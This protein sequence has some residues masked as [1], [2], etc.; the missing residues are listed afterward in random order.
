MVAMT[1]RSILPAQPSAETPV[2]A[3]GRTRVIAPITARQAR[4]GRQP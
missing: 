1:G 2:G 4:I 3:Q